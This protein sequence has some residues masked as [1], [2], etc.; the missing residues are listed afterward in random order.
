MYIAAHPT[1][2]PETATSHTVPDVAEMQMNIEKRQSGSLLKEE[3]AHTV[4]ELS[5]QEMDVHNRADQALH[6]VIEPATLDQ[7]LDV[8]SK[9]LAGRISD[10]N[11]PAQFPRRQTA[12]VTSLDKLVSGLLPKPIKMRRDVVDVAVHRHGVR[13]GAADMGSYED[14]TLVLDSL[15]GSDKGASQSAQ[16]FTVPVTWRA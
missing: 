3:S 1:L 16:P 4:D 11:L 15:A 10:A 7:P 12:D 9:Q 5:H 6:H 2:Y 14:G 8:G 13:S